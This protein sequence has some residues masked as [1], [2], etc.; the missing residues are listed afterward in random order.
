MSRE[1]IIMNVVLGWPGPGKTVSLP[2]DVDFD[3]ALE[4]TTPV[5]PPFSRDW[6]DV[7][8]VVRDELRRSADPG[9][10]TYPLNED[11]SLVGSIVRTHLLGWIEPSTTGTDRLYALEFQ[12]PQQYVM[13]GRSSNLSRRVLEHQR[14][15]TP[16]GYAM[17]NAWASPGVPDAR[18]LEEVCLTIGSFL[19]G[20]THRFERFYGME[21]KQALSIARAVFECNSDWPTPSERV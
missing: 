18:K 19:H 8:E 20:R 2:V 17:L 9:D 6:P 12:G 13:F 4:L 21:F 16:H 11:A 5:L 7:I 10:S 15:A 14:A 3:A 1:V